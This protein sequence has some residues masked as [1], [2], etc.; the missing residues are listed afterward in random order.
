MKILDS[1]LSNK[2]TIFEIQ[3]YVIQSIINTIDLNILTFLITCGGLILLLKLDS[4]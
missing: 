1:A 4:V 2:Y 3:L